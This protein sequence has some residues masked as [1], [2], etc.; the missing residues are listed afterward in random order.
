LISEESDKI[1]KTLLDGWT[2]SYL[3]LNVCLDSQLYIMKRRAYCK[4]IFITGSV[5]ARLSLFGAL[6]KENGLQE[7]LRLEK[8]YNEITNIVNLM[9]HSKFYIDISRPEDSSSSINQDYILE[10]LNKNE[11]IKS[12]MQGKFR[13]SIDQYFMKIAFTARARS[14]CM[15]RAVGSVIVKHNRI[16]SIGYNGTP[17]N[18]TNCYE[19]GCE[20]CNENYAQ[21]TGLDKCF[22]LHGEESAILEIGGKICKEATLY[23]TLFPC[24]WCAKMIIQCQIKRIVYVDDYQSIESKKIL[25]NA[26]IEITQL[27][28]ENNVN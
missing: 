18:V 22:C 5:A 25:N 9:N 14:N 15:K 12:Q 7:F 11:H 17:V 4:M 23:S 10:Q 27:E 24:L 19:G 1:F 16:L 13:P 20:R 26:K 3:I 8:R 28:Y 21:G 2:Q 6:K